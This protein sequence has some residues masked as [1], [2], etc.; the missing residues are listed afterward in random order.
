MT[1]LNDLQI[2]ELRDLEGQFFG[3][4]PVLGWLKPISVDLR[5]PTLR[6]VIE[7]RV[8]RGLHGRADMKFVMH[9]PWAAPSPPAGYVKPDKV[10]LERFLCLDSARDAS[11]HEYASKYG[12]LM[13][14]CRTEVSEDETTDVVWEHSMVW[15]YFARCMKALL[16]IAACFH[17]GRKTADSDWQVIGDRPPFVFTKTRLRDLKTLSPLSFQPEET[18]ILISAFL[19]A[20]EHRDRDAWSRLLNVLLD[21]GRAR[22]LVVWRAGAEPNLPQI[23]FSGGRLMAYLALQLSLMALKQEGFAICSFCRK[24]YSLKRAPKTGQRNYC[25]DCRGAGVP[26]KLA[27]R[28]SRERARG[29]V[30][31]RNP[32]P[33]EMLNSERVR[34]VPGP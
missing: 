28:A 30:A 34:I 3:K 16:R 14:F 18:W 23:V 11:I 10:I 8:P 2:D 32:G 15:R 27:H 6:D 17:N 1:A 13:I 22:P 33:H 20:G 25:Q 7:G 29:N 21:L 26:D 9:T 31:L 4:A 19:R 12:P 24:Q 5:P